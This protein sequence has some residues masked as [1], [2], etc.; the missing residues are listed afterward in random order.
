MGA[1]EPHWQQNRPELTGTYRTGT[2]LSAAHAQINATNQPMTVQPN[3]KFTIKT[4]VKSL[5]CRA[6]IV[7]RKYRS[8][9]RIRNVT[10]SPLSLRACFRT[11]LSARFYREIRSNSQD[12]FLNSP[13]SRTGELGPLHLGQQFDELLLSFGLV[14]AALCVRHLRDVHRAECWPTH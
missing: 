12:C 13:H 10:F 11:S 3:S 6:M 8:A 9:E 1:S 2:Y 4:P 5:L 14:V 7:G